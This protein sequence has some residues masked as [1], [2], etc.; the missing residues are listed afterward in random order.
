MFVILLNIGFYI[1][2]LVSQKILLKNNIFNHIF[3]SLLQ[4]IRMVFNNK[5]NDG[6]NVWATELTMILIE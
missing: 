5:I 4:H 3:K 1:L 2:F 6:F